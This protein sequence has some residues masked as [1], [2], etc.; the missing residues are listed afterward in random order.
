M[1]L[2][3]IEDEI[4]LASALEKGLSCWG[5]A[6][7]AA[8]EGMEGLRKALLN[9]YD[10]II[11][12]LNLPDI[13]GIDICTS[14]RENNCESAILMLTAR[15]TVTDK[16][17]GLDRGADDYLVKPFSFDELRARLHALIRRQ[18]GK[19]SPVI[20]IGKLMI[21]P[22][23]RSVNVDTV[24]LKLTA[25]EFDIL[26]YLA[27]R[28]PEYASTENIME[29]VWNEELNPFTNTVKVHIANLKRKLREAS[30]QLLISTMIGKG[31]C[32]REL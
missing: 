3:I 17:L 31:Y 13:D 5:F 32:L 15:G 29:H 26:E 8:Y 21:D 9:P 11:L 28:Y 30:G 20:Y 19:R 16:T 18:H 27:I 4:E 24:S 14:L 6:V 2:L 25:R 23:K 7:D 22:T 1:R 12:D 10:V